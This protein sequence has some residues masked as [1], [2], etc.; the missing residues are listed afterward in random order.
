[1]SEAPFNVR[2]RLNDGIKRV[3]PDIS[4]IC[5]K[6]KLTEKGCEGAPDLIVEVVSPSNRMHDYLTKVNWYKQ[7]GVKEYWIVDHI[8]KQILVYDFMKD[9]VIQHTFND[10]IIVGIWDE[11]FEIDFKSIE[12]E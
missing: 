8:R 4:I 1:M 7:S 12:I 5:D 3:E 10:S 2:L 11:G 9:D 6:S